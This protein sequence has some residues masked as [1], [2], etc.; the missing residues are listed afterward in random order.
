[1]VVL[2]KCLSASLATGFDHLEELFGCNWFVG[3]QIVQLHLGHLLEHEF[4]AVEQDVS[5]ALSQVPNVLHR[6]TTL[7]DNY[8]N[9]HQQPRDRTVKRKQNKTECAH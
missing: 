5:A 8:A 3:R 6:R 1:M 9:Q 2:C 4:D 7:V